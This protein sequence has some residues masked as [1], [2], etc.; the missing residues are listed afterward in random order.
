MIMDLSMCHRQAS[1][2]RRLAASFWRHMFGILILLP[3]QN[4]QVFKVEHDEK[5]SHEEV[6]QHPP[7]R[8]QVVNAPCIESGN[9]GFGIGRNTMQ[10]VKGN[11]LE[12][13][14]DKSDEPNSTKQ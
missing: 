14:P 13:K 10:R 12:K 3:F 1:E 7:A 6:G 8:S 9:W 11:A 4:S 2:A 5:G